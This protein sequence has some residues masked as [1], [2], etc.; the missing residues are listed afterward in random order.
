M[1]V[2]YLHKHQLPTS[3]QIFETYKDIP[4]HG[5]W[6]APMIDHQ[7]E[8]FTTQSM[9]NQR[10]V[11]ACHVYSI[12]L[13]ID[14]CRM[15]SMKNPM[16]YSPWDCLFNNPCQQTI[17]RKPHNPMTENHRPVLVP[18]VEWIT[19][20]FPCFYGGKN[21][22]LVKARDLWYRHLIWWWISINH[23]KKLDR[24]TVFFLTR[25]AGTH[26]DITMPGKSMSSDPGLPK[27]FG[28]VYL[29]GVMVYFIGWFQ[30]Y[31]H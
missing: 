14:A 25:N 18:A 13:A 9:I 31:N 2:Y 7:C 15:V 26:S 28:Y 11:M 8:P 29:F 16:V 4:N 17:V 1:N 21:L 10:V 23:S 6:T 5:G 20:R 24:W 30:T 27:C 22:S 3:L 19:W 12:L